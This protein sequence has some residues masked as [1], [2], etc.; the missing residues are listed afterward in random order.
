MDLFFRWPRHARLTCQYSPPD[1]ASCLELNDT[2]LLCVC[3]SMY[4]CV[5]GF[6]LGSFQDP[7]VCFH[8]VAMVY[9]AHKPIFAGTFFDC[10]TC[11]LSMCVC[12]FLWIVPSACVLLCSLYSAPCRRPFIM[13]LWT[14]C[15]FFLC[16]VTD[17]YPFRLLWHTWPA[18]QSSP[19]PFSIV[20]HIL[21]LYVCICL[22]SLRV[23]SC[24]YCI[25]IVCV[26]LRIHILQV[27]M[28]Y[29]ANTHIFVA[30]PR[31]L[32]G[33]Q[34]RVNPVPSACVCLYV[35]VNLCG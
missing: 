24:L 18:S 27:T 21:L 25:L 2:C 3:A 26:N 11:T 29:M 20:I 4:V 17:L 13:F 33:A 28:M 23:F 6:L 12:A 22:S 31:H 15:E 35:C 10:Y 7:C 34:R 14:V 19:A 16:Y 8:Q 30:L 9:M 32:F 5:C 1:S